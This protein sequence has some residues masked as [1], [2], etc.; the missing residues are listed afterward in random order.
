[1]M[2]EGCRTHAA[3]HVCKYR[4]VLGLQGLDE[5]SMPISGRLEASGWCLMRQDRD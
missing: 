3:C 5:F 2:Y 4:F 1:M